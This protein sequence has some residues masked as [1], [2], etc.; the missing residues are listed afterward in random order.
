MVIELE[1]SITRIQ[2]HNTLILTHYFTTLVLLGYTF[3]RLAYDNR[4]KVLQVTVTQPQQ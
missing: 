1:N 2:K 4:I 3:Q